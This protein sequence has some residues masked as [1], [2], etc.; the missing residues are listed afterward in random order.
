[1]RQVYHLYIVRCER[2]D[3]LQKFLIDRGID[4]KVH[5]PI[6]MHL[7]PA[8]KFLGYK[9]GDFPVCEATVRSVLSLP[10]HEF[11]TREQQDYVADAISE[12][13]HG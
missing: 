6:P 13:F 5:Y 2:R 12:F 11:I 10:V 7:Q 1:V 4:A 8:A 9:A 3:P